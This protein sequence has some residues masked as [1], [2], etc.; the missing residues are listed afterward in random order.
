VLPCRYNAAEF[1]FSNFRDKATALRRGRKLT[2]LF[3]PFGNAP[4]MESPY[5]GMPRR[6]VRSVGESAVALMSSAMTRRTAA[7]QRRGAERRD[8]TTLLIQRGVARELLG[9]YL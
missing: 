9:E 6:V 3:L 7:N 4:F 1:V 2:V 8:R 5:M